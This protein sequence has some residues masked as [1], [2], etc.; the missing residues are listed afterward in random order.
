[1]NE[2]KK[3]EGITITPIHEDL[4]KFFEIYVSSTNLYVQQE[5]T[6]LNK[7]VENLLSVIRASNV[8]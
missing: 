1:M 6:Q 2:E 4:K 3:L 7:D 5:I 8:E